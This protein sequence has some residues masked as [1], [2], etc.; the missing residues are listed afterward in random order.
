MAAFR[1][2]VKTLLMAVL[3]T[4]GANGN[5]IDTNPRDTITPCATV[6]CTSTTTC[7][8]IDGRAQCVPIEGEKCGSTI[9][10][11]GLTCC[12]ASCGTCTKPGVMCT[13]QACLPAGEKCGSTVCKPGLSCCN[14]SCGICVEPGKGCT[15]QFCAPN[16]QQ[17]GKTTCP[18]GFVC[19][20]S[21]CGICTPP[22]GACT[23]QFCTD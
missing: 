11:A 8:V 10:A 1:Y 7:Q 18:T 4:L 2:S 21:S 23:Q 22:G 12:N 20:N 6:K 17:C 14:S 3:V 15:K 16:E 5:P 9:C 19:C 13:Q